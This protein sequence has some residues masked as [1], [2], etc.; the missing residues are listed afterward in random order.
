MDLCQRTKELW[1]AYLANCNTGVSNSPVSFVPDC[2]II[3][4]GKH[5]LYRNL[6]QFSLAMQTEFANRGSI[7]F[8]SRDFWCTEQ[9]V[10]DQCSLVYGGLCILGENESSQVRFSMDSRFT[11]LYKKVDGEWKIL[12]LHQSIPNPEQL[13]G[14]FYPRTLT[15]QI[16]RSQETIE[17]LTRLAQR[18][19]LTGLI[20]FNTL[21]SIYTD[22]DKHDAWLFVLDMDDFKAVNDT[23]GHL[24]GNHIL[25]RL[26]ELLVTT[27][28]SRDL[29]CRMGGDEFVLLC[30]GLGT[31][32]HAQDL[33]HR[34]LTRTT[35]I[36][37]EEPA[38]TSI[39]IGG[40]PILS[41]DCLESAFK[42][43]DKALYQAKAQGKNRGSLL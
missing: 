34:L 5:E 21:Q 28:R 9:V 7:H 41:D 23:H 10:D 35:E 20:N 39:S 37:K 22:L 38:W 30:C 25:R 18:D 19:S 29:V 14:E 12:H 24:A 11:I 32:Q 36:S 17:H 15:Q 4:T 27:V 16:K 26:A 42:R 33:M 8:R 13:E 6:E 40:T 3:G 31:K 1:A 2:S 43:A